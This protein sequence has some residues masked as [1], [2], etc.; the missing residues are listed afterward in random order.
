MA[1]WHL[2]RLRASPNDLDPWDDEFILEIRRLLEGGLVERAERFV[3]AVTQELLAWNLPADILW[4]RLEQTNSVIALEAKANRTFVSWARS[5]ASVLHRQWALGEQQ[6]A[7]SRA[8]EATRQ[9]GVERER[10]EERSREIIR[11]RPI[12]GRY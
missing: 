6:K 8:A 12:S 10:E 5:R 3:L 9:A 4:V 11:Q 2:A 1:Q 7:L